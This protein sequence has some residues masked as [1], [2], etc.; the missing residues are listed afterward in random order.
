MTQICRRRKACFFH[1][2]DSI[3]HECNNVHQLF[4]LFAIVVADVVASAPD[5]VVV[6]VHVAVALASLSV[7]NSD[8]D[9]KHVYNTNE[10][11]VVSR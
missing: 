3:D 4:L 1:L 8:T 10:I 11:P 6:V 9:V 5:V 2:S 7:Y